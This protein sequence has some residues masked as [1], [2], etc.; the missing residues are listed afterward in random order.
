[1]PARS[2]GAGVQLRSLADA[3]FINVI[4]G[5][6]SRGGNIL[7]LAFQHQG[8]RLWLL[9]PLHDAHWNP[10]MPI[11]C[12]NP[13]SGRASAQRADLPASREKVP[14]TRGWASVVRGRVSYAYLKAPANFVCRD[15]TRNEST[16][17]RASREDVRRGGGGTR[18]GTAARPL[19]CGDRWLVLVALCCGAN[20]LPRT[21]SRRK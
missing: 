14:M 1:M 17:W 13:S 12:I 2:R 21:R 7:G 3:R 20:R 11:G 15:G 4:V 10:V 8:L 16:T 18:R 6:T 9:Q 19:A 5:L